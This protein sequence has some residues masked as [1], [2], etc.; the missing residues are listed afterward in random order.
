MPHPICHP[1]PTP[2]SKRRPARPQAVTR[3]TVAAESEAGDSGA[4]SATAD[5]IN[6]RAAFVAPA[7]SLLLSCDYSQVELRMLAHFSGGALGLS[8]P[9]FQGLGF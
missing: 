4:A 9:G 7:G 2:R 6:V 3:Y 8:G 1:A 5:A